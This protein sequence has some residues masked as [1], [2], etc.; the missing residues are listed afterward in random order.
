MAS[1][2]INFSLLLGLIELSPTQQALIYSFCENHDK[3]IQVLEGVI[4][5]KP[6]VTMYAL[7][8]KTQMKA[9]RNKVN[10]LE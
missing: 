1:L 6:E 8:A 5:N 4:M 3:A 10:S 9:K 7:L 2:L